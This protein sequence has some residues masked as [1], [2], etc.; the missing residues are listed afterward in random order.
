MKICER[1]CQLYMRCF[2]TGRLS[3]GAGSKPRKDHIYAQ[4]MVE[5]I[6]YFFDDMFT[7]EEEMPAEAAADAAQIISRYLA[8]YDH[9]DDQETWFGKIRQIAADLGYATKPKDY[10]KNPQDYKGHVGHVSTVIR[11][12]LMGRSQSPD[13]WEIQQILGESRTRERLAR[14]A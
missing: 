14:F 13:V 11:I 1:R 6:S 3:T 10:K 9:A 7:V 2:S 4:Q 8:S 5:N 12:A